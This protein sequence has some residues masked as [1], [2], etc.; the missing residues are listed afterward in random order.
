MNPQLGLTEQDIIGK[1]D[2]DF[3][4]KE[5]ADKLTEIK[6]QMLNTGRPEH[7]EIPLTS[8]TGEQQFFNGS[9]IP[10]FDAKGQ[11]DGLIGYFRNV[12]ER[13]RA[14][15]ALRESEERSRSIVENTPAGYFFIDREGNFRTV[16]SAWLSMHKYDSAEEIL[17]R[18][19]S[20]T[21]VSADLSNAGEIVKQLI[22]GT[23]IRH[24]E[25]SYQ[26]RINLLNL[27]HLFAI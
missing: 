15:E 1:T 3:L 23:E 13:K 26:G 4:S 6:R 14:E 27:L 20:V 22:A 24:G 11:A 21:Q 12:T 9:Y 7:M 17:G 25:G 18:P 2:H 10:K 5:D 16:N 8:S 19:F